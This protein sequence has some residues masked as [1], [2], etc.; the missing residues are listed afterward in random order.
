MIKYEDVMV[1]HS[2]GITKGQE[3]PTQ[4]KNWIGQWQ[5]QVGGIDF[6]QVQ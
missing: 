4:K 1:I 5:T 2:L 3:S 6:Q